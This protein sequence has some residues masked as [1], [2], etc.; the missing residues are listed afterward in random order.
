MLVTVKEIMQLF[1]CSEGTAIVHM[2]SIR[3]QFNTKYVTKWHIADYLCIDFLALEASYQF[4]VVG[5]E[6]SALKIIEARETFKTSAL[7]SGEKIRLKNGTLPPFDL[8]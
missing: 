4:K 3:K 6:Q 8:P 1:D 5:D 7:K 2:K